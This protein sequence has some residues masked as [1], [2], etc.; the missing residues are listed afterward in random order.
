MSDPRAFFAA[1][2]TLLAW[3]RS[4]LTIMGFGFVVARFGLFLRLV[5]AQHAEVGA[6]RL[7]PTHFSNSVGIALVLV[8]VASMLVAAFQHRSF[9]S[10]LPPT[11]I[12]SSHFRHFPVLVALG[13][14]V[15]GV[16]LA[17]YLAM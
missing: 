12:P 10:S 16:V 4:G 6:L 15:L 5:A 2:R 3:I 7:S 17:A 11:D 14:G 1:E 9:L 13:L 8:G